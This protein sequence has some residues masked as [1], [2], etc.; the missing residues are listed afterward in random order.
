MRAATRGSSLFGH[1]RLVRRAIALIVGTGCAVAVAASGGAVATAA[2]VPSPFWT[3]YLNGVAHSSNNAGQTTIT[4]SNA[5]KLV[6]KWSTTVGAPYF[7]S[8]VVFR[9]GVYIGGSDGYFYRLSESTGQVLAKVFLGKQPQLTCPANGVTATASIARD[10]KTHLLTVYVSGGDG[11]M[12]ALG[13][14]GLALKWRSVI[15]IPSATVNDYYDWSSPTVANGK[16]YVGVASS[17][18]QPLVRAG[19]MAFSQATGKKLATY[20]TVPPRVRGGSV[21]STIAVGANGDLFATTGNGPRGRERL[22]RSE[23]ILK[24]NPN[25]LALLGAFQVPAADV[26]GDGDFGASPV[27][28]G[29][30]VGACNKNGIFY[31]VRQSNMTLAWKQR[32]GKSSLR[33]RNGSCIAAPVYDGKHL[34]FGGNATTIGTTATPGSVQ[35]RSPATGAL[36]WEKP[37]PGGV[38]GAPSMDGAAVLAVDTIFTGTPGV[39]LV[40]AKTGAI[41]KQLSTDSDFAQPAWA[42]NELFTATTTSLTAWGL[43]G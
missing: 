42:E 1:Q 8:P 32:I 18:D 30:L 36:I 15:D 34:F 17:C 19:I 40:S 22:G 9:G 26:T 6:S 13:I 29:G 38:S 20:Y 25:T 37:L 31:A 28:F 2:T 21:W 35:E 7:S 5:T 41:L 4:P 3:S 33:P 23:S 14:Y 27:I 12:Y 39:F 24:F 10:P 16:V 43:P 11:Y